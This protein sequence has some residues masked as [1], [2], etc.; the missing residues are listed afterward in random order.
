MPV[1]HCV[2]FFLIIFFAFVP[3]TLVHTEELPASSDN[4][5]MQF[6]SSDFGRIATRN[7]QKVEASFIESASWFGATGLPE[8]VERELPRYLRREFGQFVA[9]P[10]ALKAADLIFIGSYFDKEVKTYYWRIP[11]KQGVTLHAKVCMDKQGDVSFSWG[12][13]VLP[14]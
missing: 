6:Q 8:A 5:K 9:E 3:S 14:N 2:R 1:M 13:F 11:V 12:D 7:K 4:P 10:G